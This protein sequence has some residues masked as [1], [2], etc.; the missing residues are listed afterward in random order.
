MNKR[1]KALIQGK[2]I[3]APGAPRYAR[4]TAKKWA[5]FDTDVL[6]RFSTGVPVDIA[7]FLSALRE[8]RGET[9]FGS[10]D[11]NRIEDLIEWAEKEAKAS[12]ALKPWHDPN[13]PPVDL[14]IM[15]RRK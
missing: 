1:T 5:M 13:V 9:M 10:T 3:I 8:C 6:Y 2:L 12:A 4:S 15:P 11:G 14:G 7:R